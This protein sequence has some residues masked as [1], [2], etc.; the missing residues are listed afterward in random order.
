M[1]HWRFLTMFST[2]SY[3]MFLS[4]Y[5]LLVRPLLMGFGIIDYVHDPEYSVHRMYFKSL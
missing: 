2:I 4:I 3:L 1:L 5:H